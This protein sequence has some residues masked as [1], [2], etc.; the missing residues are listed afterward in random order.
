MICVYYLEV[1]T[2]EI[3]GFLWPITFYLCTAQIGYHFALKGKTPS[4]G[5]INPC[6]V[7][8]D[9]VISVHLYPFDVDSS[10]I[11][12]GIHSNSKGQVRLVIH[13]YM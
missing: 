9:I 11:L 6:V 2:G 12:V 8:G 10:G 13:I 4:V 7:D 3:N 1:V 5:M